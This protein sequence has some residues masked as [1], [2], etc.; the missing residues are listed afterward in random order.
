MAGALLGNIRSIYAVRVTLD[1]AN[2]GAAGT[3]DNTVTVNGVK[4]G[5]IVLSVSKPTTTSAVGIA[6]ARVSAANT[7]IITTIATAA[8]SPGSEVYT[9]VLARPEQPV[10]L[11]EGI[12]GA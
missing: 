9:I 5:D 2:P 1:P 8:A 3:N 10:P 11:D 7:L 6:H 12:G 4:V